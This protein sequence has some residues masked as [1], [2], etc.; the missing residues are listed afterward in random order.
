[1]GSL[2]DS[3]AHPELIAALGHGIADL[4]PVGEGVG[5]L[6]QPGLAASLFS[7]HGGTS[8]LGGLQPAAVL[9]PSSGQAAATAVL[10]GVLEALGRPLQLS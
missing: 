5:V 6:G 10:A 1:M 2:G 8:G 3:R 7:G 9:P 4:V